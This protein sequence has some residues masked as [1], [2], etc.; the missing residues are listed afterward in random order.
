MSDNQSTKLNLARLNNIEEIYRAELAPTVVSV[1]YDP[2][3][4]SVKILERYFLTF[5]SFE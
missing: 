1:G 3:R 2:I 5:I 4:E